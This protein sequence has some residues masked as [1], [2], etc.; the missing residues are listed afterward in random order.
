MDNLA[1]IRVVEGFLEGEILK[2][3]LDSYGIP[4][5]LKEESARR[6]FGLTLNGLG[7]IKVMIPVQYKEKAEEILNEKA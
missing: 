3:K 6:L 1:E 5:M 4:C 7:K 2:S